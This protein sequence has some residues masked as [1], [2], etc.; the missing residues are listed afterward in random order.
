MVC[1]CVWGGGGVGEWWS[2][3]SGGG[4]NQQ[5]RSKNNFRVLKNFKSFVQTKAKLSV[6]FYWVDEKNQKVVA[7]NSSSDC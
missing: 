7:I 6:G 4:G 1:V 3:I 2:Q 5:K